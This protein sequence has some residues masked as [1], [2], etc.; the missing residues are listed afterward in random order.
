MTAPASDCRV[1]GL[2]TEW[3][4]DDVRAAATSGADAI[5]LPK[6]EAASDISRLQDLMV[7]AGAPANQE[8]WAHRIR[9]L[10][11]G[12]AFCIGSRLT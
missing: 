3:F 7:A 9:R 2:S 1:N 8:I 11:A 5:L 6:T 12:N 4:E 10:P